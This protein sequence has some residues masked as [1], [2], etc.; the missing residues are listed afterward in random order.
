MLADQLLVDAG[1]GHAGGV[2][3][4]EGDARGRVDLDGVAVA[5]VELQLRAHQLGTV[6]HA[7]DLEAAAIAFGDADDHVVDE[8]AGQPVELARA[9][10]VEGPLDAQP[11]VLADDA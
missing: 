10:V 9:L 7:L 1:D 3:D 4:L 6:A 8:R 5:E 11:T 2:L